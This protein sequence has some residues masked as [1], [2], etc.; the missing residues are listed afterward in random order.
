MNDI[1]LHSYKFESFSYIPQNIQSMG[2]N[3]ICYDG[4]QVTVSDSGVRTILLD[5][6]KR[7]NALTIQMMEYITHIINEASKDGDKTKLIY[8]TGGN[9]NYFSS[10]NDLKNYFPKEDID[11]VILLESA[12]KTFQEFV[13]ALINCPKIGKS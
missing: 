3:H 13:K 11:P 5:R 4:L 8:I 1:L 12:T 10:G 7:N 6:P 9:G 2:L